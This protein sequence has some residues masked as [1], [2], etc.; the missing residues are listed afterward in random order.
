MYKKNGVMPKSKETLEDVEK[1][2]IRVIEDR[3]ISL[4]TTERFG[5][6]TAVDQRDGKTPTHHYYPYTRGETVGYKARTL[7]RKGFYAVGVVDPTCDLFGGS[8]CPSARKIFVTEGELDCAI[9]YQVLREEAEKSGYGRREPAVVSVGGSG[10][11]V[12]HLSNNREFLSS[13]GEIILVFDQDKAGEKAVQEVAHLF[14]EVKYARF[15][16]KD[17]CEMVKRGK[18]RELYQGV[19][20]KSERYRP[21]GIISGN[22]ISLDK[23]KEPRPQGISLPFPDLNKMLRGLRL[24]E[25]TVLIAPAKSGKS[26]VVSE[27]EYHLN[28]YHQER[29]AAIHLETGH[30]EAARHQIA[31]DNDVLPDH[32]AENPSLI[33]EEK[34]KDSY[35]RLI[36]NG[37]YFTVSHWGSLES[38]ELLSKIR[39]FAV[40]EGVRFI[41][42]DHISMI[43]SGMMSRD[44]RQDID[45]LL[46][47]L[48]QMVVELNIH[49][50]AVAHIKRNNSKN[51]YEGAVPTLSD[52][53]GSGSFEQLAFS[54]ISVARDHM[55]ENN[56]R[57]SLHLLANRTA[58]RTGQCDTL[59]YDQNTGRL[60]SITEEF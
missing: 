51:F 43:F 7:G 1:L 32:L 53:R 40:V 58:R 3:G 21:K 20:F 38:Q 54:V 31:L 10:W 22:E 41:V 33:P 55:A 15:S 47:Q 14:P 6:R 28:N 23:L 49:V 52:A 59:E 48:A 39:H 60:K 8:V 9:L 13:F 16:E 42:L 17:P 25:L 4:E 34:Y 35:D 46:T 57:I 29:V 24:G 26:T 12:E 30:E 37:R 5:I 27:I 56:D 36:G 50:I 18:Q 11:A 44:E 45:W 19:L 2:P